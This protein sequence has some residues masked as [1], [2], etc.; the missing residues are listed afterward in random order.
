MTWK[1]PVI[2]SLTALTVI[3]FRVRGAEK[4]VV[5]G[6]EITVEITSEITATPSATPTASISATP[7]PLA[8]RDLAP[9][10][11]PTPTPSANWRTQPEFTPE[12]I[13]G[14]V[15]KYS[16]LYAVDPNVLRYVIRCESG[17][18]PKAQN[19]IYAGLF[20]FDT[21]TWQK[22]RIKMGLDADPDLRYHAE[23]AVRTGTYV[24]SLGKTGL[25]PNCYP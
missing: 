20:Q 2:I 19:Y 5:L 24:L 6:E 4:P 10:D 18:N 16:I 9:R 17:F 23:E 7:T 11:K 8:K 13:H 15:E 14:F 25:W 12:Q 1:T 3:G 22:Y 21:N